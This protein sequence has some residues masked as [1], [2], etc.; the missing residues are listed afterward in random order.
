MYG[1]IRFVAV[2]LSRQLLDGA[3]VKIAGGKIHRREIAAAA[4][5]R[6]HR[7]DAFKE[8]G[9]VDHRHKA[10]GGDHVANCD[11]DCALALNLLANNLV[12]CCA[13]RVQPVVQPPQRGSGIGV[14]I[15]QSLCELHR[16]CGGP[17]RAIE[18]LQ[19]RLTWLVI[20]SQKGIGQ[21]IGQMT[22]RE[23][24]YD[25]FRQPPQIFHQRNAERDRECP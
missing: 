18:T 17:R 7:A 9:P 6:I 4:Q 1:D 5:N 8:L 2:R 25:G 22:C 10:H 13:F 21:F 15:A 24:R 3:P 23:A 16:K 14:A 11:V 20:G 12:G 19:A